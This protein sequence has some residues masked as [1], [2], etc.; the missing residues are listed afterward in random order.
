MREAIPPHGR[1]RIGVSVD[2]PLLWRTGLLVAGTRQ[3]RDPPG[4]AFD[5]ILRRGLRFLQVALLLPRYA[6]HLAISGRSSPTHRELSPAVKTPGKNGSA[7][8]LP[9]DGRKNG[10]T[11]RGSL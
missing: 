5:T 11:A 3:H 9:Q 8:E 10:R 1:A 7:E 2:D 4:L 6:K